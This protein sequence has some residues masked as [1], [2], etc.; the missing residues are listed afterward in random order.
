M[1]LIFLRLRGF[2][3]GFGFALV[4]GFF[5]D[6]TLGFAVDFEVDLAVALAVAFTVGFGV[7]FFVAAIALVELN[8]NVIARSSVN[9]LAIGDINYVPT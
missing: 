6:E 4:V 2:H 8:A 3:R 5:V 7:G 9:F 1:S